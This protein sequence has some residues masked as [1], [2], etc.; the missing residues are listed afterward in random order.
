MPWCLYKAGLQTGNS[1]D[2]GRIKSKGSGR[3]RRFAYIFSTEK[4]QAFV[5]S[6][7]ALNAVQ[8]YG[9]VLGKASGGVEFNIKKLGV[10]YCFRHKHKGV[11]KGTD[12][13]AWHIVTLVT[14]NHLGGAY[15]CN[16]VCSQPKKINT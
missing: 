1:T 8:M 7:L 15:L 5:Y 9:L 16:I 10:C 3:S 12:A 14:T 2:K 13:C 6:V 4:V 11:Q